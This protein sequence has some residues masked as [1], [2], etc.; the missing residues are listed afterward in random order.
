VFCL[1]T[2]INTEEE[3][4]DYRIH[5][6]KLLK[7]T[8]NSVSS[9]KQQFIIRNLLKTNAETLGSVFIHFSILK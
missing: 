4:Q 8:N 5:K 9:A 2:A 3:A 1:S 7:L 6:K